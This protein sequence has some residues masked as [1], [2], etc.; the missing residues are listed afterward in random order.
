MKRSMNWS[1][2]FRPAVVAMVVLGFGAGFVAAHDEGAPGHRH[3]PEVHDHHGHGHAH[4]EHEHEHAHDHGGRL[5][6]IMEQMNDHLKVLRRQVREPEKKPDT[7]ERVRELQ[8]LAFE[9]KSMPPEAPSELSDQA[10]ADWSR[11]YRLRFIGVLHAMLDLESAVLKD[12]V[13]GAWDQIKKLNKLKLEG[14]ADFRA[15]LED[16]HD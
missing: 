3:E 13:M 1:H 2:A 10:R 9:A 8:A 15:E 14:H 6:D 11:Q 16:D 5:H 4:G 12:E 7:L